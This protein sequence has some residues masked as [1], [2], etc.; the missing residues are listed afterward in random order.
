MKTEED[1]LFLKI[2]ENLRKNTKQKRNTYKRQELKRRT[3]KKKNYNKK[4]MINKKL[5][6]KE[7]N[8]NQG[9]QAMAWKKMWTYLQL[10]RAI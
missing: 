8:K 10:I 2:T 6:K 4:I 7:K 3:K 9:V 5:K 1:N